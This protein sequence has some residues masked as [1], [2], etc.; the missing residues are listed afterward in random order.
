M[1]LQRFGTEL[2]GGNPCEKA[3][4]DPEYKCDMCVSSDWDYDAKPG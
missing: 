1:A 2:W 3:K 4:T